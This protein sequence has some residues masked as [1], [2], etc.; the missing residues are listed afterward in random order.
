[1]DARENMIF[2]QVVEETY[3]VQENSTNK[4]NSARGDAI[5]IRSG[6]QERQVKRYIVRGRE[7]RGCSGEQGAERAVPG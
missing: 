2:L 4:Q 6:F 1:M 7:Q 5:M 3:T